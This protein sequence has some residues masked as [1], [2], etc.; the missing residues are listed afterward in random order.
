MV[1]GLCEHAVVAK[2][3]DIAQP[4]PHINSLH[5]SLKRKV[6]AHFFFQRLWPGCEVSGQFFKGV[7]GFGFACAVC[8]LRETGRPFASFAAFNHVVTCVCNNLVDLR[9]GDGILKAQ[10]IAYPL[11][12]GVVNLAHGTA[13]VRRIGVQLSTFS[14]RFFGCH[15]SCK[16]RHFFH[17]S[18]CNLTDCCVAVVDGVHCWAVR[19]TKNCLQAKV[20]GNLVDRS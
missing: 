4:C 14:Q 9:I 7:G 20:P 10:G 11:L 8:C 13:G 6:A 1:H 3:E 5:F 2:L 19:R 18:V 16:R 17:L 12:N 15:L